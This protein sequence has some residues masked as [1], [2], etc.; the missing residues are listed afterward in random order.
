M[1]DLLPAGDW[2]GV[3]EIIMSHFH[4]KVTLHQRLCDGPNEW[5]R[6]RSLIVVV[7]VDDVSQATAP[8]PSVVEP[9]AFQ[10]LVDESSHVLGGKVDMWSHNCRRDTI[11]GRMA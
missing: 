6:D 9:K 3:V 1:N 2:I 7:V 4:G 11:H 10:S 8:T 5:F